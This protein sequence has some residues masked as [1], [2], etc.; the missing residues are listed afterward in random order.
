MND[1]L[2]NGPILFL[3][4]CLQLSNKLQTSFDRQLL[5]LFIFSQSQSPNF[6]GPR[7]LFL[8]RR[9]G[10]TTLFDVPVRQAT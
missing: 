3:N 7:N 1:I 5:A 4:F 6:K 9:A 2:L 8:A 10:T